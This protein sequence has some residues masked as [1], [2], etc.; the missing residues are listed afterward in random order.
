[1][2]KIL[3]E[4]FI[5]QAKKIHNDKY[6]YSKVEYINNRTK[7]CIIC[8]EH[9]EFWQ[10]PYSHLIGKGCKKCAIKQN[11][12][13]QKKTSEEFIEQ[14]KKIHNDKYDYSKV[15]YIDSSTKICVICPKHGEFWQR[16]ND[17]L[18]GQGCFKCAKE[19]ISKKNSLGKDTFIERSKKI[20]NEFYSYENVNYIN[21]STKVLVTCPKHG[22]FLISPSNH[23]KGRGCPICKSETYV[24][25]E[26]LY[27]LLLNIF[28]ENDII[29]Q[30]KTDWL[31]N[32][33][34]LD[35]YIPK[36]NIA[37]EHQ[38]SQHFKHQPF[39]CSVE[40]FERIKLL[41]KEKYDECVLNNVNI[42]YFSYEKYSIPSEYFSQ[43]YIDENN[44]LNKINKII[45]QKQ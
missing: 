22:G 5:E 10:I 35:F 43:I 34:S 20:F 12:E 1:M 27:R 36:Y 11:S 13:K 15:E 25:E 29:R 39:L 2:K 32:N 3:V 40:K 44:F 14:A 9:G 16:P 42:L 18:S 19:I 38:G 4:E 31:T 30:Y 23:L 26:R 37:V 28:N 33:K 7:V 24:Y 8:P 6:D 41:D 45:C 21:N 17:H